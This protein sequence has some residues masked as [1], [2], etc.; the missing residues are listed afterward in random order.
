MN[1]IIRNNNMPHGFANRQSLHRH[2]TGRS[3]SVR[4]HYHRAIARLN[5]ALT[6]EEALDDETIRDAIENYFDE[7]ED[8]RKGVIATYGEIGDWIVS[9][10]TDMNGLFKDKTEFNEDISR[11]D[12]GKVKDMEEMFYNAASFNQPV[13][14]WNVKN[15][16]LMTSMFQGATSFNEPLDNWTVDSVEAMTSMFE[17][18][19]SFDQPLDSWKVETVSFMACM[20]KDATS[21]NQSLEAWKPKCAQKTDMFENATSLKEENKP[22]WYIEKGTQ[23]YV[24]GISEYCRLGVL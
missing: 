8:K 10:V 11:W 7:D 23:V 12:T 2:A 21:F 3:P 22:S 15:V 1:Q 16:T 4:S 18:A 19:T 5:A 13:N 24:P 20:F 9:E 6:G 17:G 14:S